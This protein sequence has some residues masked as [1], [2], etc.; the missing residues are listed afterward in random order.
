MADH[1][2]LSSI[3]L[4]ADAPPRD[5]PRPPHQRNGSFADKFDW[6]TLFYDVYRVGRDVVF[7][8]PPFYGFLDA[9]KKAAPFRG[10]FGFPRFHARHHGED[11]RGEIWLRTDRDAFTIDCELGTF[12]ITVQPNRADLFA[13]RRVIFTM[14]KDNR[15][16]WIEDWLRF[17]RE[18]HGADAALIYDNG[19]TL[20][21]PAE[22]QAHLRETFPDMVI[23][24]LD[25]SF[26]YG[27]PG[28]MS[29]A[30]DGQPVPFDCD[31]AQIG[32]FQHSRF[33]F[34][35]QAKSV[36]NCDI[37]ELV[38]ANGTRTVFEAAEEDGF[39]K[40]EGH[41]ITN[42]NAAGTQDPDA[43]RHADFSLRRREDE[44]ICPPKWAVTPGKFS[45]K[46][47]WSVHN[48][49]GTRANA[50]ISDEFT[51]R[52]FRGINTSWKYDRWAAGDAASAALADERLLAA[53]AATGLAPA[54]SIPAEF[55]ARAAS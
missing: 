11:K 40:F 30:V 45:R 20:Y 44:E 43:L 10:A 22:L 23:V 34:F 50:R 35:G 42:R 52:H 12:D 2:A 16:A 19:S 29:G 37:D 33:R 55:E 28:G 36:L 26:P 54:Q 24:V 49:F 46:C 8:G 38:I 48:I 15:I 9:L 5:C 17:H 31:F 39:T 1:V 41:W 27:P 14:S 47:S 51:Y 3:T 18:L 7:Q 32:K 13:G 53:Y 21:S 25:W 4:P 6:H